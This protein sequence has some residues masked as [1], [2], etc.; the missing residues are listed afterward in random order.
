MEAAEVPQ[1]SGS[2][3]QHHLS[4][5]KL[6]LKTM[7]L[8]PAD[9]HAFWVLNL[10][11]VFFAILLGAIFLFLFSRVARRANSGVPTGVENFVEMCVEFVQGQ[12][13]DIYPHANSFVAPL[14]LTILMWVLLM[15][16]M[17]IVPVDLLPY[18]GEHVLGL[19]YL[20]IVPS[21]D[22]N[23]TIG[24]S[25]T[26]FVIMYIYNFAYKGPIGL[27]KEFLTHPFFIKSGPLVLLN[28]LLVP[29]NVVLRIVEDVAKPV[30]LGL[31]LFGNLF[32]GELIFVLIAVF[33]SNAFSHGVGGFAFF[34]IGGFLIQMA[35]A[36]FH[37]LV[38]P[39][40]AFVFMVLTVV[41]LA[42]ASES[43]G[44]DH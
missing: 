35:W 15:N 33:S 25:L 1:D 16:L 10:D 9:P 42:S 43:H 41:Y 37:V 12:V 22:L 30:S 18:L 13:K 5:L 8:S 17:D 3:V 27:A 11:S 28:I 24:M 36:A 20:R 2:Y 4:N 14:G 26:V 31:R 21:T 19:P 34:G 44:E 29:V 7:S 38:I 40:Q 23:V 6:D 32:A 39:L